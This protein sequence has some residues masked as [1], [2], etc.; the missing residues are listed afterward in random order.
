MG[1]ITTRRVVITGLGTVNPLANNVADTWRAL[2]EGKSGVGRVSAFDT[3][4]FRTRIAA[5]VKGFHPD[6]LFGTKLARRLDRYSQFALAA[7]NEAVVD[8]GVAI[9]AENSLRVGVVLGTGIG[10]MQAFE[11]ECNKYQLGGPNRTNPFL[12]P[13][14]MPNA[15]AAAISIQHSLNGPCLSVSTACASAA[16]AI[17]MGREF[18]RADRCDVVIAGGSEAALTP[19]GLAG[20]CAARSLSERNDMPEAASRPFDRDRDGFVLGEGAGVV[21]LEEYEHARRRGAQIYCELA[22]CGQSSDA[23]HVT[24]PDPEGTNAC[25]AMQLAMHDAGIAPHQM[26][27]VNAHATST[28]LG[29]A[30][31]ARAIHLAFGNHAE[32]MP[33]SCTK[34][35]MGHLCGGSGG[36]AAVVVALTIKHNIIHPT[37]NFETPDPECPLDCVPNAAREVRVR[38]ALLNSFGFGGHNSSLAFSAL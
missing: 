3:S 11:T 14:M 28:P 20:F 23:Y 35:M 19:L 12:V 8:A 2:C 26:D 21:V 37:V 9:V 32:R 6:S 29:D 18:I 27:Y 22:G 16:D 25:R 15:A 5:E 31:E 13:R 38:K 17:S 4:D 10:G 34:S 7:A 24:A 33:V 36:V 1:N 30:A